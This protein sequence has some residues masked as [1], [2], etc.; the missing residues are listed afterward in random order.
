MTQELR[1]GSN[2]KLI[3]R[4]SKWIKIQCNVWLKSWVEVGIQS[5]QKD[6]VNNYKHNGNVWLKICV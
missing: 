2:L 3:K 5:K 6:K 4:Q 1:G